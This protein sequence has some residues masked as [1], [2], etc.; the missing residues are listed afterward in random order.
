[1]RQAPRKWQTIHRAIFASS[2]A[3]NNTSARRPFH[4][5]SLSHDILPPRLLPRTLSPFRKILPTTSKIRHQV[6][7]VQSRLPPQRCYLRQPFPPSL[8]STPG[9]G[10]CPLL[11]LHPVL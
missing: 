10:K 5:S 9:S 7:R 6:H 8:S 1:M 4:L 2:H 11:L 3:P